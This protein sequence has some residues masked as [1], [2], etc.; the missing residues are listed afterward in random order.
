[1]GF[2]PPAEMSSYG[3][4]SANKLK[5]TFACHGGC[6]VGP[7]TFAGSVP[8][9]FGMT[10]MLRIGRV[11]SYH[12]PS[13]VQSRKAWVTKPGELTGATAEIPQGPPECRARS[14]DPMAGKPRTS[15]SWPGPAGMSSWASVSSPLSS[16]VVP[17]ASV[18]FWV[19]LVPRGE[20]PTVIVVVPPTSQP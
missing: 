14:K 13:V 2:R 6:E 11:A 1:F 20:L 16:V 5:F 18:T 8:S 10:G 4:M 19:K 15:H 12:T 3:V 9:G 7:N 17:G